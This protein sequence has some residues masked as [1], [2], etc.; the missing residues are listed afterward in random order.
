MDAWKAAGNAGREFDDDL[1][2][3]FNEA[4]QK[5][6]AKRNEFY[7]KLHAEHDEKYAEKQAL[8]KEAK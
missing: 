7:E 4:R 8:V 2:N 5:F 3:A 1:W 6:Y